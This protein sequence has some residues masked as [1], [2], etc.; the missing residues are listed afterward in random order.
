MGLFQN[1]VLKKHLKGLDNQQV[2]QAWNTYKAHFHNSDIQENIRNSKEEQYQEGFLR[3][4]FVNIFGYVLNPETNYNLTT[5]LKN[6]KGAKKTDGAILQDDKAI[7]V[8]ELKGTNTVDLAKVEAQAFGYKNNQPGCTYV[9][10]SNFEK[11]RFYIDNTVDFEEFNLFQLTK[12]RFDILYLC[13][14][15]ENLLKGTPKQIEGESLTQEENVTKKLYKDYS[16]FRNEI[17]DNIQ[18]KNPQHDKLTLFKKTQKLLDRF[19]FIF[20]AEDRLLLPPNSIREIVNQWTELKDKFDEYFP[21]YDRFKKY[22]GYMNTGKQHEIFAYNGGLFEPDEVLNNISID[23]ELL[24]KHTL[25]LSNYDFESEVSVNILG[26]IFEHSLTEIETIQAELSASNGFKPIGKRISKRKKDGVFYTPKYITKYIVDNTVGKL[27]QEKKTE[28]SIHEADYEKER[29]SRKKATIKKLTDQLDQYREWLLQLTISDPAC[30]SGAFL[31]QA[32][33]F[34]IEEHRYIDELQTKLI[35]G[36]IVFSY[37]EKSILENNLFGVDINEESVEIAKLS[38][39]LR[40]AQKGRKLTTLNNNIKCGNSLID[41]PEV[42]GDKAFDWHKEFPEIFREK[43]K[44]AFHIVLTTH[45]SRTSQRM[46]KLGIEKGEPVELNLKEEIKLTEIIGG[47][48]KEKGYNCIAYNICKDHVHI[49]LVCEYQELTSIVKTIKGKSSFE[50]QSNGFKPIGE[51][52][53]SQKFFRADLDVWKPASISY[54]PGYVYKDTHLNNALVYIRNNRKKHELPLSKKLQKIIDGFIAEQDTAFRPEYKGGFD[55]V[56][57]NPPYVKLETI[58][59]ESLKLESRDFKTFDKRG[60]L[61]VLFVEKGFSLLKPKGRISYIMPNKWLQAG[62]G[63][64]LRKYFLAKGLE[65]LIDFGDIQIFQGATTYPVIFTA[66]NTTPKKQVKVAVLQSANAADFNTN[67]IANTETFDRTDFSEDTWVISSKKDKALLQ[68][69]ENKF[70]TLHEFVDGSA[71]RGVLTGLTAAFLISEETKEQIIKEDSKAREVIHP[72]LRGRDIKQ[73]VGDKPEVFLIGTFPALNLAIDDYSSVKNHFWAFGQERLQQN[74]KKGSRKK[75]NNKWFETQDA[76]AYY[77]DFKKPKIMYQT[78][79]VKPCFIYDEQGLYCNNSMW[80]IPTDKKGLTAILNSKMGWWLITKYCTQIQN[81]VQLIW[82]YFGKVPI[83]E[84]DSTLDDLADT[85]IALHKQLH[86]KKTKFL[87]RVQ[88][89]LLSNGTDSIGDTRSSGKISKK[90]AAFY[91]HDFKTFVS[92]IS[93]G[94]KSLGKKKFSLTD[95]DEW[96]EYF[97]QYKTEINQLQSQIEKTD[98]EIDQMVYK[99]YDLTEDEIK[100]VENT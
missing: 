74:G 16:Q 34:L 64:P 100:V 22:F 20:F 13:L 7:A 11:L 27:C 35:G 82:K 85:M 69:L 81:G 87:K 36:S 65:E 9:I 17:F 88:D 76:I 50:Y 73:W 44:Q 28:L 96:E 94:L 80:I 37:V 38:L 66:T 77:P 56:I 91:D 99:L 25:N 40:T 86:Q 92:E 68:K 18:K 63:K 14:A 48:I 5:E 70:K 41:D 71:L 3:D 15:A 51:P 30:G 78:F 53:W 26:H 23:D 95:Q 43:E 59:E 84:F 83:P 72:I 10:T 97:T 79:Q 46:M 8:I 21:L 6:L 1:S 31:N 33:E 60:D 89:N 32:L 49:I 47:I 42:A 29:K 98:K 55:V 12:E 75:T 24:H 58:K 52:L 67:V 45:N 62:Y 4:L 93:K 39:W 90:M 54:K 2:E 57:G 61:Y 19:L